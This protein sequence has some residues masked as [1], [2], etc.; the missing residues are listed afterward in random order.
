MIIYDPLT[1]EAITSSI[2]SH[3]R[4]CFLMTRLGTPIPSEVQKIRKSIQKACTLKNFT[5]IDA[6]T[7]ITGR[8]FLRKIWDLISATPLSIGVSHEDI[9][10]KTQMNIYYE[11]G[12]AQALGKATIIVK[13]PKSE[14]PSDF[15]RTEYI[16]YDKTFQEN[17]LKYL[18]SLDDL[19][20]HYE[21]IAHQLEKNPVLAIDYLRRAF[22]ITGDNTLKEK[23]R[24]F[25]SAAGLGTRAKNSVELLAANF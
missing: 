20:E 8:D 18:N 19:A 16:I 4:H 22:L 24:E 7:K 2:K 5:L 12:I 10:I 21:E 25:V 13:S 15:V 6:N 1:G 9:P 14:I 11:I 3:P 23:A 17:F